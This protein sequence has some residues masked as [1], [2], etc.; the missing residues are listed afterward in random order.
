MRL[1][2]VSNYTYYVREFRLRRIFLLA[3]LVSKLPSPCSQNANPYSVRLAHRV[4]S[5]AERV[6]Q[7]RTG[8][9]RAPLKIREFRLR[10]IFLLAALV[11]ELPSP[12]SQN[13]NPYSARFAH[14][15]GSRAERVTKKR[16]GA[17]SLLLFFFGDP[18]GNR[19]HVSSV[20]G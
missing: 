12:C 15:V 13:A 6:T 3:A 19:T 2:Y 8:A 1:S 16:T 11:S 18:Y 7:K 17:T 10:R 9:L 5:R 14:R 20:R 4:G